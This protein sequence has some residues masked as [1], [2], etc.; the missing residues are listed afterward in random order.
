MTTEVTKSIANY[1]STPKT[2]NYLEE[3]L[4][5]KS[6]EFISNLIT[7]TDQNEALSKCDNQKLMKC[8]MNATALNLP[9]NKSLGYAYVIPYY[10]GKLKCYEPQFQIGTKGWK[11]LA[12]RSGQYKTL[13]HC[14][15]REGEMEYNKFTGEFKFIKENPEGKIVG[16]LAYFK[17]LNGYAK[18]LYMTNEQL[19]EHALKYSTLYQNDKKNK[20]KYSKWSQPDEKGFMCN[21]TVIKLLLSRDGILSTEMSKAI[22]KDTNTEE[23]YSDKNRGGDI[24]DAEIIPQSDTKKPVNKKGNIEDLG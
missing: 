7:L 11:Q 1:L 18:S 21:K 15:I 20:T 6:G 4:K 14:E 2:K 23:S 19:E 3:L 16:Y 5:D 12:M 13:N 17:L 22:E 8:A 9:L 10:N 24:Q